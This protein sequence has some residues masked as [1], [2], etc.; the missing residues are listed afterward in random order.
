MG[1]I[2]VHLVKT[3]VM[4]LAE[5]PG[6]PEDLSSLKLTQLQ[7][8][9]KTNINFTFLYITLHPTTICDG[10]KRQIE[11]M[12]ICVKLWCSLFPNRNVWLS[13]PKQDSF[14]ASYSHSHIHIHSFYL[15]CP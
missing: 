3:E 8:C 13:S 15:Y 14:S 10:A 9:V 12:D 6:S 4:V 1:A 2:N 5:D 11:L 7:I